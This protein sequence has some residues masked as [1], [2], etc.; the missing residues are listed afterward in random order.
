MT[1]TVFLGVCGG[2]GTTTAALDHARRLRATVVD[3]DLVHGSVAYR[4]GVSARRTIADLASLGDGDL[5][6]GQVAALV[7]DVAGIR[8]VASPASPELAE[9]V[10]ARLTRQLVELL[11][12]RGAVVVDGGSRL[13]TCVLAALRAAD[14]VVLVARADAF[15]AERV[16][17]TVR[18]C[19]RAGLSHCPIQVRVPGANRRTESSFAA[20][21]GLTVHDPEHGQRAFGIRVP[22]FALARRRSHAGSH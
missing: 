3:M 19:E 11:A 20:G 2:A 5:T 21:V 14:D 16:R 7:Y 18:L 9:I 17:T 6:P 10:P 13:D 22:R 15:S 12:V 8:L 1:T 4:C